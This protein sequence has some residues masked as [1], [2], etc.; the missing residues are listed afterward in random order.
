MQNKCIGS[1]IEKPTIQQL[2]MTSLTFYRTH[3]FTAVLK[4][5]PP[6]LTI[7]QTDRIYDVRPYSFKVL[8]DFLSR[9]TLAPCNWLLEDVE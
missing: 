5:D 8:F 2:V 7:I 4:K 6:L 3:I 9:S 1:D